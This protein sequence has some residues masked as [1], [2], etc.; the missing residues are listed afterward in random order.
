MSARPRTGGLALIDWTLVDPDAALDGPVAQPLAARGPGARP[1]H[2]TAPR[3][4]LG[5]T[6]RRSA[7]KEPS[8]W[9]ET[10]EAGIGDEPAALDWQVGWATTDT[11]FGYWVADAHGASWG[12]LT[13]LRVNPDARRID[14]SSVLLGPTLARRSFTL[15]SERIA[16]V[17]PAQEGA[18]GELRVRSWGRPGEGSLR[19]R[20]IRVRNGIPAF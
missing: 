4:G 10:I 2:G 19:I 15:G 14:R 5:D 16:W 11:T 18:D 7:A 17:A 1:L 12:R 6:S 20:D 13:V 9:L 3:D 8:P